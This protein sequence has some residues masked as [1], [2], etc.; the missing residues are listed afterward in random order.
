MAQALRQRD[1]AVF[2]RAPPVSL[3]PTDGSEL[4]IRALDADIRIRGPL[5]HTELHFVFHNA[6]PRV[7]EGR[8]TMAAAT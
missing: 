5:A 6:E 2:D 4:A 8:F 7:H 1:G 3:T